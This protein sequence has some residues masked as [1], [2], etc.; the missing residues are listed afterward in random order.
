MAVTKIGAAAAGL[1]KTLPRERLQRVARA[2]WR[3]EKVGSRGRFS[4][5]GPPNPV[6][7]QEQRQNASKHDSLKSQ[8][9][10][11][12]DESKTVEDDITSLS[13]GDNQN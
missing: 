8:T 1:R 7:I 12:K 6:T 3:D 10:S 13:V 11:L 4:R 2:K 9:V 5:P